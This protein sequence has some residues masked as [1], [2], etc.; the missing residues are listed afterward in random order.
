MHR[1]LIFLTLYFLAFCLPLFGQQFCNAVKITDLNGNEDP[2]INCSYPLDGSCLQLKV[3]Y[4]TFFETTSYLVSSENFTPYGDFNAGTPLNADADDLF[5]SKINIP[6]NFCYF[7][8]NYSEVIVGS[9]GVLTFDRTQ[10]GK[11]N[12]PNVEEPNPSVTLPENS[13]FG[14]FSDLVFSKADDSEVYY[15]IIGTAPCR[16]LVVNFYKGRVLGCNQTVTS[17]IVLSEGSN[18]V[19]IFVE[20]KPL[21]CA[22]AKFKNSLLGIIN[23][24]ATIGYSPAGRNSGIW[25]AQNEAWKF[26]PNGNAIIPQ[27]FWFN[28]GNAKVGSGDVV[29]VCPEKDEIYTAKVS[30]PICGNLEYVLQD[31]SSVTYA[32]DYPLAKNS[33]EVFCGNNSFNVNL[34]DYVAD[35]TPQNPGNLIFSFYNSLADAQNAVNPQ[36]ANFVLS[37]NRIFYVRVQS[38]SEPGCF[39]TAVLNLNLISKSLLTSNIGICDINN[40]GVENNFKLALFNP[41][42]FASPVNGSIHY[43]LSQADAENNINEVQTANLVNGFQFY[44][45]YKTA[46]CSQTF[47]PVTLNFLSSPV[48]NSPI[49]LVLSTC[50][51]LG[52]L[53]EPFDFMAILGSQV[54]SDPNMILS[55]YATYQEAYSGT[56]AV[57]TTIRDGNYQVYV[58]VQAPGGCFSIATIN[59]DITFTKVEA[60]DETVYICFDGTKDMA[61]DLNDYASKMLLQSPIGITTTFF[62]SATDAEKDVNPI[63]N[64]QIITDNGDLVTKTFYVKFSDA[65]D[66]YAVRTIEI[67]LVHVVIKQ[68]KFDICDFKNDGT[69]NVTLSTLSK[70]IIGSQN[71]SVSY[72][73][74]L[75]DAQNNTNVISSYNVQNTAKLFV[76]I[77]SYSCSAVFE[78][79]LSLVSTPVVKELITAVKNDVCDNNNDGLEPFDLTSYES[80]IYTGSDAVSF[81]YYTGYN[82]ANNSLTGLIS[83]PSGFVIPKTKVVYVKVSFRS[84]CFSVST[85]NI[86][87]NFL[88]VVVLKK[89]VLKKC[90]YDF[91]LNESFDLTEA[92]PQLFNPNENLLTIGDL[93][94]SY[95]KT[96]SAAN[97]G[98]PAAQISSP[99]VTINSKTTVWVR[100]TSKSIGCYS[101]A[102]IELLTY[103]PPKAM[104]AVIADLCDENLDG[105]TD[106]DLT[107][108]THRMV[109]TE[110]PENTFSFFRTKA[111]ADTNTNRIANPDK[112]SFGPSLTRI[113]VRVENIPGCF[114][115]ASIDL[116]LGNKITFNNSG[117]FLINNCDTGNDN[118]ENVDLTQF[119]KTIYSGT[120]NFEYYP[121]LLDINN[122]TNIIASPNNYLFNENT[123]PET[124][125]AKVSAPGFCPEKVGIKLNLKKTPMFSLPDYYFCPDGF[126]DIK[127]DFSNL[128][129]VKFEWR[130]PAGELIS[131]TQE[132]KNVK[133]AGVYSLAVTASNNCTFTTDV[134]VKIYEVPIIT[135]LLPNGNSY[136][137]IATGSKKILYSLD[138]INYQDGNVFYNLPYGV[139]TFYVKFEGSD[140]LGIP[141]KG[142]VLNIRNAFSPNDD[143]INDTWIIDDLNVFEGQKTN[144]KVFNRFKEKIFEQESATRLE[145]DGKTLGRVVSTDSYWYVLTLADGRVFTGW[146]LVKNRN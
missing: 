113:W 134:N 13:I 142:L 46:T 72:F 108:F 103:L 128:G 30:Y 95:Y 65:T 112:F 24:G 50:D 55:F 111:D 5:F 87:L 31:T 9:N 62:L 144:L 53:T 8:K 58:R 120:A 29:K 80:E 6:F 54:T 32:L 119:E 102:P 12:Y 133:T 59:L 140:C 138:G 47:G 100:F 40:D 21:L 35:L 14:V 63:S 85:I 105:L 127:P 141:K 10:L 92:L 118:V 76:R 81:Q 39:R 89:A 107:A 90:D 93:T 60:K 70:R 74:N 34:E 84:G 11:V 69:E 45:N 67:N 94:V 37:A 16:K 15:S 136:T 48:V 115:T 78:I 28:S 36:P 98:V 110:D 104:S 17:Q 51:Y 96:E 73:S 145:W 23:S 77:V 33:T 121:T 101:V 114:D 88:P 18:I 25:A 97:A 68:S 71:A 3:T 129:I 2:F 4:P 126:V 64:F 130:N 75:T 66:C 27:V 137:V 57:L 42:L 124:I 146:V 123:G 106:V 117:P 43:F 139:T 7:G 52:D 82:P 131:T 143:G 79:E 132:L 20:N 61:V 125:F 83:T 91:N 86:Q 26:M 122:G 49:P 1:I 56:G 44:V 109:Y 135:K 41:K 38:K 99:V 22:D 116:S 19:E